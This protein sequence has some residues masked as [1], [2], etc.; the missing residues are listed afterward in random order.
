MAHKTFTLVSFV[1]IHVVLN[2]KMAMNI[3]NLHAKDSLWRACGETFTL[4]SF[5]TIHV[6]LKLKM[7]MTISNLHAKDSM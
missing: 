3:S 6:I 7:A 4:V 1:T 2:L 5:V